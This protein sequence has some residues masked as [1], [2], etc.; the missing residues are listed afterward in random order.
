MPSFVDLAELSNA[1]YEQGTYLV[2]VTPPLTTTPATPVPV[3]TNAS[4]LNQT[5]ACL[6]TPQTTGPA[7][8][9]WSK[10]QHAYNRAGFYAGLYECGD[11]RIIAFRGTDDLL[12]ALVDDAAIAGGGLPPQVLAA[13]TTVSA[14]GFSGKTYITGH[15]LGGAL[16]ILSGCHFNVP[17]VTFNAPGVAD[18]CV[19]IAV[20]ANPLKRVLAAVSRCVSNS[21]VRNVR[22]EGDPVSSM[23]TTGAQ[24]GGHTQAYSGASCGF[25]SLCRHGMATCLAA[26]KAS[27]ANYQELIL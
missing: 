6:L 22:I 25:N 10:S 4:L 11:Q 23:F 3:R 15:S 24:A 8:K 13:F 9:T 20:M 21:R 1:V 27:D 5:N 16:A 14:W 12:D 26:V 17:A 19:Q 7:P 18:V 2:N